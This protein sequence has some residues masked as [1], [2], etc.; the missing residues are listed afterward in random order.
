[1]DLIDNL[2]V[3]R[4]VNAC[5]AR[6]SL[7]EAAL[8]ENI[9]LAAAS[10][11]ISQLE[12]RL[13][14]SLLDRSTRP[15]KPTVGLRAL[16]PA[17]KKMIRA[18]AEALAAARLFEPDEEGV[19]EIRVS[20]PVNWSRKS[21]L[22]ALFQFEK[23]YPSVRFE[24]VADAGIEGMLY[25]GVDIAL[26]GYRPVE[27]EIFYQKITEE[28]TALFASTSYIRQYG[29][30][31]SVGDLMHHTLLMRNPSN[32]SFSCTLENGADLLF[33]TDKFRVHYGDAATCRQA[34]LD[35]EGIAV[36]LCFAYISEE[37]AAGTVVPILPGWHREIWERSVACPLKL[38]SDPL[39]RTLMTHL[40]EATV[41]SFMD[42]W[43]FWYER[44][45]IP[46]SSVTLPGSRR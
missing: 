3:W 35:G 43:Q 11:M 27:K 23:K 22:Q 10:R 36:D 17:A 39:I 12:K 1:M 8:A 30:P 4:L 45:G 37:L 7:S 5:A 21:T 13:G 26:L 25:R 41:Q 24:V 34:L 19:R 6:K 42:S 44:L 14:F 32:R 33:I 28:A 2:A 15:A 18:Q 40:K 38:A 46:L 31:Q 9:D 20:V 16:A 29:E